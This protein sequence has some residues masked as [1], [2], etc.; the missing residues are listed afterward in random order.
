MLMRLDDM[1]HTGAAVGRHE[2]KAVFVPGGLPGEEVRAE[3]VEIRPRYTIARLVEVLTPSPERVGPPCEHYG[4]CGGCDWQHIAYPAQLRYKE[5]IVRDQLRRVGGIAEP[6]VHHTL[7]MA[8]PWSYRN[9]MQFVVD[10]DGRLCLLAAGSEEPVAID[11]CRLL[12]PE[13]QEVYGELELDFPGL[14]R[15]VLRGSAVTGERMLILEAAGAEE[16][17]IEVD[18]PLS[19]VLLR[20]DGSGIALIGRSYYHEE[21]GG[22]RL[23]VSAGSF[24]QINRTQAEAVL[25]L[26]R[27]YAALQAGD[28]V[29][30][31]YSG[32][33]T[34]GLNLAGAAARVILVEESPS[35]AADARA[36]AEGLGH[37]E[38]VQG[39]AEDVLPRLQGPFAVAVTDPPRAGMDRRALQALANLAP[40]R[41]VY[42]SCDPGSL[43]RDVRYLAEHGYRLVEA[44]PVDMFP[45]THH[46]ETVALLKRDGDPR[47][48]A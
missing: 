5:Q 2:G 18:R 3:P 39:A 46:V 16:P 8:D 19:C 40:D 43:A 12:C 23:R 33:G 11:A 17:E 6:L 35:A 24:F 7:G 1:S 38:V 47:G 45:Q 31:L 20:P 28:A 30:D 10:E 42:V 4:L 32:V 37:V 21:I 22:R 26:V 15:V 25:G 48:D 9:N 44:T 29:L 27:Q 34:F 36:N 41:I 13:L 14:E